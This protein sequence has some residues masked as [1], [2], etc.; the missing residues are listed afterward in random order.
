MH[1]LLWLVL[2]ARINADIKK[3]KEERVLLLN[4]AEQAS[5][6][7]KKLMITALENFKKRLSK[8]LQVQRQVP[9]LSDDSCRP[10]FQAWP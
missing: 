5:W 6:L 8:D 1:T 2:A 3:N 10:T 7:I 4:E 9:D